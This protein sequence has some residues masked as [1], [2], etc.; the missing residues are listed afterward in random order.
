MA[1]ARFPKAP[2]VRIAIAA[3][4]AAVALALVLWPSSAIA[5]AGAVTVGDPPTVRFVY[6]VPA[7]RAVQTRYVRAIDDAAR[8]L[9][10]WLAQQLDGETF[11][12]N[13]PIVEVFHSPHG[14][15]WY[16]TNPAGADRRWWFLAN[17]QADGIALTGAEWN[18][19]HNVWVFLPDADNG[20]GPD[21]VASI[22]HGGGGG[23]H[24]VALAAQDLRGLAGDT[25]R[26]LCADEPDGWGGFGVG[27]WIGGMGHELMHALG[28]GHPPACED[29][30]SAT[31][32]PEDDLMWTGYSLYPN[33]ALLPEER[34]V[35]AATAFVARQPPEATPPPDT[36]RTATLS[37]GPLPAAGFGL[38]TFGGGSSRQ[39][40]A[41]SG[42]RSTS[43]AFWVVS[44]G[45]GLTG[46]LPAAAV[47]IVNA[48]WYVRFAAGVPRDTILIAKCR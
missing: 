31:A 38:V 10:A 26:K 13:D 37:G 20:C 47:P 27:R 43:A 35:L 3:T 40:L 6:I 34:A 24:L 36:L 30:S 2:I 41:A 28:V 1:H 21:G 12:L 32:C 42:C 19:P 18:D 45:G 25:Y 4:I 16:S 7:D 46:Y 29:G 11:R 33:S 9:Q 8:D 23:N 39:L 44:D 5:R 48:A 17:V 14:S 15:A 22:Q